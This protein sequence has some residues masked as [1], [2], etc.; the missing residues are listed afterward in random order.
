VAVLASLYYFGVNPNATLAGLGVGGIAVALAAQKTLE[1][2][3][4]GASIIFDGAVRVGD[5]LK[6]GE[7]VGTV[8][9]IGLRSTCLRTFDR[10]VFTVPN[11]QMANV[12]LENLSLRDS[13][14]FHHILGLR[15]ETTAAQMRS[16][17]QGI[18]SLLEKYPLANH[19]PMPVRFLRLGAYSLD[20]EI[21]V[22]LAARDWGHFL[23]LQGQ[24]LLQIM[25]VIETEGAR[26]AIPAQ[27]TYLAV[28]S[29]SDLSSAQALLNNSGRGPLGAVAPKAEAG[30]DDSRN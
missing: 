8:E 25:E 20:V 29:G 15:Y 27:T 12:N 7:K 16:V 19:F 23:E 11:G 17:L 2:V 14:W 1:N 28:S 24:L 21:F 10:T 26:L 6:V 18:A 13:F 22:H 9:D 4:G 5:L 3:I 30:R